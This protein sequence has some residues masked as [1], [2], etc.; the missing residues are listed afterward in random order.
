MYIHGKM[1]SQNGSS[2]HVTYYIKKVLPIIGL[3]IYYLIVV[4]KL[5]WLN[6][7]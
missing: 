5:I 1:V 2:H 7:L 3:I 4:G 6:S